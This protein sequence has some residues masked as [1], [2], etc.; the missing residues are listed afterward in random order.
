MANQ[1]RIMEFNIGDN[2][3]VRDKIKLK[4]RHDGQKLLIPMI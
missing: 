1:G 2:I 4:T 3:L